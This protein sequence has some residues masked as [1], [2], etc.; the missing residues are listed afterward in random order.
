MVPEGCAEGCLV[1]GIATARR[2]EVVV[3]L[4]RFLVVVVVVVVFIGLQR[5][6]DQCRSPDWRPLCCRWKYD[7]AISAI[8]QPQDT[9]RAGAGSRLRLRLRLRQRQRTDASRAS[10]SAANSQ[11][12][13]DANRLRFNGEGHEANEEERRPRLE[14]RSLCQWRTGNPGE[15]FMIFMPFMV[16]LFIFRW[17]QSDLIQDAAVD[18]LHRHNPQPT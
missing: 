4:F 15:S 1:A 3:S 17:R 8:D 12:G 5:P 10:V 18:R 9:A 7:R 14:N 2:D 16:K 6:D 13:F 11:L